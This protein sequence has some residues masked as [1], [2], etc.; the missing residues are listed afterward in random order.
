MYT[1]FKN[2][3]QEKECLFDELNQKQCELND[4]QKKYDDFKKKFDVM[5]SL[6]N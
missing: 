2:L 3:L 1:A 5:K 4:L 6:F